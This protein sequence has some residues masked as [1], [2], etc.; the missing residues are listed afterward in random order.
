MHR[1]VVYW[2]WV[3]YLL[4]QRALIQIYELLNYFLLWTLSP[5]ILLV[6]VAK[7]NWLKDL[8]FNCQWSYSIFTIPFELSPSKKSHPYPFSSNFFLPFFWALSLKLEVY[9]TVP[10]H[11]MSQMSRSSAKKANKNINITDIVSHN[12]RGLKSDDQINKI[13]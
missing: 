1:P 4:L 2:T 9:C 11:D 6:K 13:F 12:L 10:G 8:S 5:Y 7:R 3:V